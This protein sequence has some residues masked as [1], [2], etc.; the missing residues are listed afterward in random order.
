MTRI[1]S[2]G[3]GL[4]IV[5]STLAAQQAPVPAVPEQAAPGTARQL[6]PEQE[7]DQVR[8]FAYVL[9][10]QVERGGQRLAQR[11]TEI[12]AD[13]P[14]LGMA[15]TPDVLGAPHPDGGF[16]F[17]VQVPD[18]QPS[19]LYLFGMRL[20]QQQGARPVTTN[21]TDPRVVDPPKSADL[22]FDPGREY[23]EFVRAGLMDAM[24]ENSQALGIADGRLVVI[25]SVTAEARRDPLENS[26]L[27]ILSIKGEDLAA[28]RQGRITK[29]EVL[30]RITDRR[31]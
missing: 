26:R 1:L 8:N 11:V 4:S 24:V 13:A 15:G 25:A 21:P 12:V 29:D 6:T 19:F 3:V 23:G 31:F 27:L 16:V 22:A 2:L 5:G 14:Q 10:A 7:K 20:R 28:Y 18:I 9:R 17:T 30:Q